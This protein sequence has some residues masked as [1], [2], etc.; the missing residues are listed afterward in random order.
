MTS[1]TT[2]PEPIALGTIAKNRIFKI[3]LYQR[4][5][6]WTEEEVRTLL[7]DLWDSYQAERPHYYLGSIV[8]QQPRDSESLEVVDG[9]QRLTTIRLMDLLFKLT[10]NSTDEKSNDS[11]WL[12]FEGRPESDEMLTMLRKEKRAGE[13][14]LSDEKKHI[15]R[16]WRVIADWKSE[17]EIEDD[18]HN[19]FIGYA[20]DSVSLFLIHLP[21]NTDLNHYFEI[22]NNRGEQLEHHEILKAK[23]LNAVRTN[24]S[25]KYHAAALIWDACADMNGYV[26]ENLKKRG[27]TPPEY[28]D[29]N[30]HEKINPDNKETDGN[31]NAISLKDILEKTDK[32]G[33]ASF[34]TTIEDSTSYTSRFRS[35]VNF[36]NF[37]LIA[38]YLYVMEQYSQTSRKSGDSESRKKYP[39]LD[40]K[41]LIEH[42]KTYLVD[43]KKL[44]NSE[45]AWGFVCAILKYRQLFDTYVIKREE[46]QEGPNDSRWSLK[47]WHN[48][49]DN[50]TT[51]TF[52]KDN[53]KLVAILSMLHVSHPSQ[54]HKNW[55]VAVLRWLTL[56][57]PDH[58]TIDADDYIKHLE[59]LAATIGAR[60]VNSGEVDIW[61]EI[62]EGHNLDSTKPLSQTN[63]GK[64]KHIDKGTRTPRYLFHWLD[65]LIWKRIKFDDSAH[66]TVELALSNSN[67]KTKAREFRFTIRSSVE[68]FQP[69][70]PDEGKVYRGGWS[71]ENIDCFG[72]LCLVHSS[73]NSSLSNKTPKEKAVYVEDQKKLVS[74]VLAEM[75]SRRDKTEGWTTEQAEIHRSKMVELMQSEIEAQLRGNDHCSD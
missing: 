35:I 59:R 10:D 66:G 62:I 38:L 71:D 15:F 73:F 25:D 61:E 21:Q 11:E 12:Q 64:S 14:N 8:V 68:H 9:Q 3:P 43:S 74:L 70:N 52:D 5:Y 17:H 7:D 6:A 2:R 75:V 23:L 41:R 30:F 24:D 60:I 37:L 33:S 27:I 48:D 58:Q 44:D 1:S 63:I 67:L 29:V 28:L 53:D 40:D 72:N 36:P 57:Q 13:N 47:H 4:N 54:S 19:S 16:A 42:F 18:Q 31:D 22:M 34:E 46:L 56:Q 51:N 69:R 39:A 32:A 45:N 55:L 20:R 50:P 49:S 65:Y 26:V